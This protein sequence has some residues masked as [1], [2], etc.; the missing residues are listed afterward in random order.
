VKT[1]EMGL[2]AK[3]AAA[4]GSDPINLALTLV[5]LEDGIA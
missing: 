2:V 4:P 5:L 3:Q 1:S